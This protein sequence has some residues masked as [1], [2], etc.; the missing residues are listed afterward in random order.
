[1]LS[2][3]KNRLQFSKDVRHVELTPRVF[4]C[5]QETSDKH[6]CTEE[7]LWENVS[8]CHFET[9]KGETFQYRTY[10]HLFSKYCVLFVDVAK[11]YEIAYLSLPNM[12]NVCV[13][14]CVCVCFDEGSSTIIIIVKTF[15]W[16]ILKSE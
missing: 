5:W 10:Y 8:S 15:C 14:V 6:A 4:S 16:P 2:Y 9:Y 1:M 13:C 3:R 11:Y 12:N 7:E